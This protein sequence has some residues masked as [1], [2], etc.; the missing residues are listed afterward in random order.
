MA[1]GGEV[2][3]LLDFDNKKGTFSLRGYAVASGSK[4]SE[5]EKRNIYMVEA[6]NCS[7]VPDR[8]HEQFESYMLGKYRGRSD[9]IDEDPIISILASKYK[10]VA[11]KVKPVYA[12]LPER[13]RIKREINVALRV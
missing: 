1:D 4:F 13:Y 7:D 2:A 5:K 3:L 12:E 11:L 10:P 6:M 9:D 8:K